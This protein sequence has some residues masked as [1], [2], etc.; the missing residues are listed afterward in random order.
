MPASFSGIL[1]SWQDFY[2]M[3]GCV[4]DVDKILERL[5]DRSGGDEK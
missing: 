5:A 1:Q 2:R 3:S 4:C